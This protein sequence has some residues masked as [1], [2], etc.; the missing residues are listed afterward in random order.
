MEDPATHAGLEGAMSSLEEGELAKG[1]VM[2]WR[3]P[4][5]STIPKVYVQSHK[6]SA[7]LGTSYEK[8]II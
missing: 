4:T 1:L 2:Q 5:V 3:D 7:A 6:L 8:K